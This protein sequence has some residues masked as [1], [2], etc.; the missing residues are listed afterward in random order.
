MVDI[1]VKGFHSL[2]PPLLFIHHPYK[3]NYGMGRAEMYVETK[4]TKTTKTPASVY[5]KKTVNKDD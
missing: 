5:K 1:K 3:V 2:H 4:T